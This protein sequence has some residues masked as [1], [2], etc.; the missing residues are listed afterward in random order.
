M[1]NMM[2]PTDTTPASGSPGLDRPLDV[3]DLSPTTSAAARLRLAWAD[4][5]SAWAY[6]GLAASLSWIDIK[7]RYR[8]SVLGPFWLTLS[9]ALM[10]AS[11]GAI[12]ATLFHMTLRIYLPFLTLSLIL[13]NF[14]FALISEGCM[15]FTVA[16][17]TIRAMRLPFVVHALRVVLR[18]LL[19]LAHN[20]VV[21]AAIY[22]IFDIWP[23][24]TALLVL[25]GMVLWAVDALAV[26]ML[27]GG[28]CARFRDIPPIVAS[29]MQMAFFVTPVIWRPE[30]VGTK[31]LW[32]LPF[33][34]FYTLLE[35]VRGP[36]LGEAPGKAVWISAVL[37]SLLLVVVSGWV[38]TRTRSRIAFWV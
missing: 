34:P 9:T 10:V 18:N 11:M 33:N 5:R 31:H 28:I 14:L 38:F 15:S 4:L 25:P 36:L 6:R 27:L 20:I 37:A 1:M 30:L 22:L 16:E 7:L 32:L 21:I 26:T 35:V 12:Y 2:A 24:M 8:G 17:S 23:G 3:L 13:W 29:L 19:V